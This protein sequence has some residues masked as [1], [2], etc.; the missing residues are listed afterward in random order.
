M[1]FFDKIDELA[2]DVTDMFEFTTIRKAKN[3]EDTDNTKVRARVI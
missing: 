2:Y 3:P 1:I